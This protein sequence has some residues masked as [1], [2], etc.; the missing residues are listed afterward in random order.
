MQHIYTVHLGVKGTF[1]AGRL[2]EHKKRRERRHNNA[3]NA[4]T[5]KRTT[6]KISP[7]R[8]V[9]CWV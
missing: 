3:P 6:A 8:R 9:N 7:Q 5:K 4:E 1:I 2:T